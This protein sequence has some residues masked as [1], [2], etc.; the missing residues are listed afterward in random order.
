MR[1][2]RTELD[3]D[4][5]RR[6]RDADDRIYVVTSNLVLEAQEKLAR[7]RRLDRIERVAWPVSFL[8]PLAGAIGIAIVGDPSRF[9]VGALIC[10][11]CPRCQG[12][13]NS[14]ADNRMSRR[15]WWDPAGS[16]HSASGLAWHTGQ[17]IF[18]SL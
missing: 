9:A 16:A 13:F 6:R 18:I 17:E 15:A 7:R 11:G 8:S 3:D 1:H 4:A 14:Y 2:G 5:D 10:A 12:H